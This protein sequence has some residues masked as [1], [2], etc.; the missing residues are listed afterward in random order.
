MKLSVICEVFGDLSMDGVTVKMLSN[1]GGKFNF[2]DVKKDGVTPLKY[3]FDIYREFVL[4]NNKVERYLAENFGNGT[5]ITDSIYL[6]TDLKGYQLVDVKNPFVVYSKMLACI[7]EFW[8]KQSLPILIS[9]SGTNSAQNI[10]YR[11]LLERA[12]RIDSAFSFLPCVDDRFIRADIIPQL[13]DE[14]Q[15]AVIS[16]VDSAKSDY[17]DYISKLKKGK[18]SRRAFNRDDTNPWAQS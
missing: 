3:E 9:F 11:K 1:H 7:K 16:M 4:P 10:M 15:V 8:D 12:A 17:A 5:L 14:I 2:F 18:Q 13:P 6:K